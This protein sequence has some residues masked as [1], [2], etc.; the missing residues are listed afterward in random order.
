MCVRSLVLCGEQKHHEK[1]INGVGS[2]GEMSKREQD[3]R[4]VGREYRSGEEC[5]GHVDGVSVEGS[6]WRVG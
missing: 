4:T 5:E 6:R 2:V 3:G 1:R